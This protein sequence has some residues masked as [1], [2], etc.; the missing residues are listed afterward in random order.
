MA[1]AEKLI[2]C[3]GLCPGDLLT[4]TAA[5]ESLH[6]TYPG[7]YLTDVRTP[8]PALWEH[9]PRITPIKDSDRSAKKMD[10]CYSSEKNENSINHSDQRSITFLAGYCGHLTELLGR[11]VPLRVNRPQ[12]YLGEDEKRWVNQVR[13]SV[14][15]DR[16]LPFWLLNAGTKSDF[17]TKQWPIESYQEVV[18]RTR[19]RVLW[20]QIGEN[21]PSHNHPDLQ[22]VIDF[23]GKTDTRQLVRLA[24]HA[25]GGLGPVTFLQHLCA[26]WE[27]PYVCLLGGREPVPWTA[28]PLQTTLHTI[29]NHSLSCCRSKACWKSRVVS[30]DGDKNSSLCE[31]P[32]FGLRR[33]VAKCMTLITPDDVILSLDRLGD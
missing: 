24:W 32:V 13:Q 23:R 30:G 33:P 11:P 14:T 10:M 17:T 25:R 15:G 9:N 26:A 2:L 5:V 19:G 18:D 16:D 3:C 8:C 12:L 6:L 20:V 4:L 28:Y 21:T 7:E 1:A 27:K 31:Q 22:G 29:G